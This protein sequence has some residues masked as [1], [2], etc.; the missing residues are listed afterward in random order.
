MKNKG[1]GNIICSNKCKIRVVIYGAGVYGKLTY[2]YLKKYKN[3]EIIGWLDRNYNKIPKYEYPIPILNPEVINNLD[4]EYIIVSVVTERFITEIYN[5][6]N[7]HGIINEKIIFIDINE[8]DQSRKIE[9]FAD[10]EF[11]ILLHDYKD[12]IYLRDKYRDYI[13]Y[14]EYKSGQGSNIIWLLW[15]QGWNNVPDIV[16]ICK[17]SIERYKGNRKIIYLDKKNYQ[18]YVNIPKDIIDMHKNGIISN[19]NYSDIIRMELLKKYGG[20]WLDATVF[21]TD[22]LESYITD[23]SCFVYQFP[24]VQPGSKTI[25]TW[26]I[27]AHNNN[28]II[29]ETLKLLYIYWRTEKKAINYY[30]IH[31]LFRTVTNIYYKEWNKIPYFSNSN[32]FIMEKE[33]GNPYNKKRMEQIL[34]L[35]KIHKLTYKLNIETKGTMY[36]YLL[37]QHKY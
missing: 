21:L 6:I 11:K 7:Q 33:L 34:S 1:I 31:F 23:G 29:E 14:R 36:E 37:K 22:E 4:F 5:F 30:A 25:S 8:F 18:E 17:K 32:C 15:F 12:Y 10:N 28:V 13:E 27:Y 16:T 9:Y 35:S 24:R 19:T 3:I 26:L 2:D 20:L